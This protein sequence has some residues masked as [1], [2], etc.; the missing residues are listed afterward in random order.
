MVVYL[1]LVW[2]LNVLSDLLALYITAR[3]S[4][5]PLRPKRLIIGSLLGGIYGTLA[6]LPPFLFLTVFPLQMLAALLLVRFVFGREKVFLR[7]CI[8]FYILSCTIG[9]AMLAISQYIHTNGFTNTLKMLDWKVFFLVGAI[10]YFLLS[11]VFRGGAKH[12]IRGQIFR[13]SVRLGDKKSVLYALH[14][15]GH[16]LCDPYDGTPVLTVWYRALHSLWS[17]EEQEILEQLEAQG[18]IRCAEKLSEVSPGKFRLITYRAVGVNCAMLP[19]VRADTIYINGKKY[20]KMTLALS[21]T[22]VSDG[23]GYTALW[24]GER[25]EK[26]GNVVSDESVIASDFTAAGVDPSR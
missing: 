5:T 6:V 12:T 2:G 3:L 9:G 26:T 4:G 8:L 20:E 18:S 15:T 11:V 17:K 25:K 21:P 23:E 13:V 7:L 24:G 10:C 22:P 1:D 14:D 16:T 19:A